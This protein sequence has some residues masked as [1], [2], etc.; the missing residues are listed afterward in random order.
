MKADRRLFGHMVKIATSRSLNIKDILKHPLGLLPWALANFNG[1]L[2][3]KK[4]TASLAGQLEKMN[5]P[6]D[7]IA[8]PSTTVIDS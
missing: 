7:C 8:A 6:A 4:K 2:E 3:K 5:A 1:M